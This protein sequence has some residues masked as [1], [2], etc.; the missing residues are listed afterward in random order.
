MSSVR[1][2]WGMELWTSRR[3]ASGE[4]SRRLTIAS[5]AA[6]R[7]SASATS[8]STSESRVTRKGWFAS[9]CMPGNSSAAFA[10]M[11]C[12]SGRNRRPSGIGTNR[13]MICGTFTRANRR[14]RVVGSR[15]TIARFSDRFE[16]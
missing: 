5:V 12:S 3:T 10:A 13:G 8:S 14:M 4:R 11:S 2:N 7:S 15:T 9:I 1:T 6:S 16:M